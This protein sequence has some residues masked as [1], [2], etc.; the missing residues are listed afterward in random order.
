MVEERGLLFSMK[1]SLLPATRI[2]IIISSRQQIHLAQDFVTTFC[3][4]FNLEDKYIFRLHLIIE[5][6]LVS[7]FGKIG[8]GKEVSFYLDYREKL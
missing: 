1:A 4:R 8:D 2:G 7:L 6:F 5:E 3:N